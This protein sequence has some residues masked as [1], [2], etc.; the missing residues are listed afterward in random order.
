MKYFQ[1]Y[2]LLVFC[3]C[4]YAQKS[5]KITYE[6]KIFYS[7]AFFSQVPGGASEEF[8]AAF[9]KPKGFELTHNGDYSLFKSVNEKE[10]VIPSSEISTSTTVNNGTI[11]KPFNVWILKDFTKQSF[12]KSAEVVG[13]EYYLEQPFTI[14][15]LKYDK[16]VKLIDG[17]KCLSAYSINEANDTIQYWYTQE[18]PII[19]GPFLITTIPGLVLSVESKKKVLYVTKIEFFDKKLVI[20]GVN[21]KTPFITEIELQNKIQES[22]KPKSYTDEFGGKHESNTVIIKSEN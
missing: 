19:D 7:D 11:I 9:R 22:R 20:D 6:Q 10:K 2:F 1:F 16:R 12:I 3:N 4:L 14:E 21:K 8:I 15:E 17:Y 5:I 13:Q 18:I